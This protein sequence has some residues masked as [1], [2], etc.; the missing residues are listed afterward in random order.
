MKPKLIATVIVAALSSSA[1]A[2]EPVDLRKLYEYVDDVEP[3]MSSQWWD[4]ANTSGKIV[5]NVLSENIK[6]VNDGVFKQGTLV[7]PYEANTVFDVY[8]TH[9]KI[10]QIRLGKGEFIRDVVAGDNERYTYTVS[11][12]GVGPEQQQFVFVQPKQPRRAQ[13]TLVITTSHRLYNLNLNTVKSFY[14]PV[15][16]FAYPLEVK[17]QKTGKAERSQP[18]AINTNY[19]VDPQ[20]NEAWIPRSIWDDGRKT[21]LRFPDEIK[22]HAL[23]AL[24]IKE[25]GELHLANYR[26]ANDGTMIVVDR[27]FA[28]AVVKLNRDT[29][30]DIYRK[31]EKQP[32][33]GNVNISI[34]DSAWDK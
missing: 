16:E 28:H 27:L 17:P 13:T 29:K 7:Y 3:K 14:T 23:P 26:V 1:M 22:S 4:R 12:A 20:S 24:Y 2:Q 6:S 34:R 30:A 8:L 10:T 9:G 31:G 5:R 15:V 32:D 33:R 25:G 19:T 11:A 21:Y 18:Q